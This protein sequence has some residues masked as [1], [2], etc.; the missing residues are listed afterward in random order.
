MQALAYIVPCLLL[1]PSGADPGPSEGKG[2]LENPLEGARGPAVLSAELTARAWFGSVDGYLQTRAGGQAGSTSP[3]RPTT[4]EIGLD[5]LSAMPVVDGVLRI[6]EKHEIHAQYARV[7]LSGEDVLRSELVSQGRTFPAGSP[8]E[9]HLGLDLF[10][11]GYRARWLPFRPFGLSLSA[12]AGFSLNPFSYRLA[13]PAATGNV[14]RSYSIGFPYL[15]LLIERKV[16]DRLA[17]EVDL[18]GSGGINGVS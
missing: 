18:A 9:S 15:G 16:L 5:G 14:D 3:H 4:E 13:S 6:L 17:V 2:G 1:A 11:A 7:S 8:V 12:E 10:R